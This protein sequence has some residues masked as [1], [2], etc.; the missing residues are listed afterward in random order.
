MELTT[1]VRHRISLVGHFLGLFEGLQRGNGDDHM[2]QP[3][4]ITYCSR[5]EAR[6]G[7]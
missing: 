5:R 7:V 4:H 3:C 6:A 1:A 2:C